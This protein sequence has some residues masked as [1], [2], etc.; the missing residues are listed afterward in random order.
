MS[1][2]VEFWKR[3]LS[4]KIPIK[5]TPWNVV[6]ESWAAR[7]TAFF[8]PELNIF[9]DIGKES[10]QHPTHIF[11]SHAH[12]DHTKALPCHL[13]EPVGTPIVVVPKPSA[14]DIKNLVHAFI[15]ATKYNNN[16]QIKWKLVEVSIPHNETSTNNQTFIP[17]IMKIKNINFKI[18]I[19]K[20]THTIPTT[21]YGFI[22]LR[23]KLDDKY[24][25]LS[26]E[27]INKIKTEGVN[28]T[29]TIELSHF[30]YL[31]DTTHY[32]FYIDKK[33]TQFNQHIEKYGTIIVECTFL[34]EQDLKHS[35][36][37][38]HMHWSNLKTYIETHQNIN[39]ILSHFSTRYTSNEIRCFFN[40]V[41]YP[42]VYIVLNDDDEYWV[43]KLLEKTIN[44]NLSNATKNKL[45]KSLMTC[46]E[47]VTQSHILN[48]K[49]QII[50]SNL[51]K[52]IAVDFVNNIF[53]TT[54]NILLNK[55]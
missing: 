35:K 24:K 43:D 8:I 6:G 22:E 36:D 32:V 18:E 26:Q 52:S 20:C 21:G 29:K 41:N 25:N 46:N 45:I 1:D 30:C 27:E 2:V 37:T 49:F 14:N 11:I 3:I 10:E 54:F 50:D 7:Y 53:Q 5:G 44:G 51:I 13:L 48:N 16:V 55:N 39:F 31:G 12:C 34:N 38:K 47:C 40:N 33:C 42:N 17:E 19:F 9:L 28:V 15:K 23:T 4:K